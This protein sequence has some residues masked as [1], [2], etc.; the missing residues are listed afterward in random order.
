[1]KKLHKVELKLEDSPYYKFMNSINAQETRQK[2]E[3][4]LTD[5]MK[6]LGM[7]INSHNHNQLL[8]I[9]VEKSIIDYVIS[10]RKRVG[11]ATLK[12]RLASIY[13]F[14]TMNDVL[15]N[16]QKISKFKGEFLKVKKDRAYEHE[17]ISRLLQIADLRMKV[18]ILLM[19][20][21]GIRIGAIPDLKLKHLEKLDLDKVYKMGIH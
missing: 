18:C 6:F 10:L 12:T 8:K 15:L 7:E 13:H 5:F 20:S 14:Y 19:A 17:E 3:Y 21:S 2:Y 4:C 9:D 16:K 11:S 1:M